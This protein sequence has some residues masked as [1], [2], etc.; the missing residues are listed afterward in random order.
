MAFLI[1]NGPARS[2]LHTLGLVA[3]SIMLAVVFVSAALAQ[4][5]TE[6][7]PQTK[8]PSPHAKSLPTARIKSCSLFGA[9]F[10]NVPGTDACVK[11]GGY[12]TVEGMAK[13][14]R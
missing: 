12:V 13:G 5:L 10:V 6:P 11:I 14:A 9:G 8:I 1:D 3:A 4:T 2:I 7:N